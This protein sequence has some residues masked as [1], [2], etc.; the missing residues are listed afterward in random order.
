MRTTRR[1][2]AWLQAGIVSCLC[3]LYLTWWAAYVDYNLVSTQ[4]FAQLEPGMTA[5]FDGAEFRLDSIS[6]A[7]AAIDKYKDPQLAKTG[8]V[9]VKAELTMSGFQ[10]DDIPI[11]PLTLV[12]QD[13][14]AWEHQSIGTPI[15]E[16]KSCV[17]QETPSPAK[18]QQLFQ[19]PVTD[20]DKIIGVAVTNYDG[21]YPV[22]VPAV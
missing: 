5:T 11:C 21:P 6:Y 20:I 13:G 9:W 3:A 17:E 10:N 18:I 1:I 2:R 12:T 15:R 4:R 19:V 8:T 14:R 22:L 7:R 16:V